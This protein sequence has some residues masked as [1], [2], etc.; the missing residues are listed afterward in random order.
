MSDKVIIQKFREIFTGPSPYLGKLQ[1]ATDC[2]DALACRGSK[3]H[4]YLYT[5][6]A[7]E[8]LEEVKFECAMCDPEMLVTAD[9][10]CRMI[11]GKRVD[12][13]GG[14]DWPAFSEALGFASDDMKA[15][16]DGARKV[17]DALLEHHWAG[18]PCEL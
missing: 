11:H 18:K 17:L 13:L 14:V 1:N 3:D 9:I 12:E 15:H 8:R 4:L 7:D 10:L 16:F 2:A 6:I 5:R